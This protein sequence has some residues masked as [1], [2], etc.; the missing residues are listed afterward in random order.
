MPILTGSA[1]YAVAEAFGWRYGLDEKPQRAKQFYAVIAVLT[2]VGVLVNFLGI[3]PIDALFWTAVINGFLAP[4]MLII[5]MLI[6]NNRAI[7]GKRV[8]SRRANVAGWITTAVM[9]AAV[10]A[11]LLNLINP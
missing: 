8:N 4:P 5:L 1:A 9:T 6:A 11:L 7:V 10:V 3:N 2:V